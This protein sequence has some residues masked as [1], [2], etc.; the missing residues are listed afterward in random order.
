[1]KNFT[2]SFLFLMAL[3]CLFQCRD[4]SVQAGTITTIVGVS[5][6][7]NIPLGDRGLATD[8]KL[9]QPTGIFVDDAGSIFIADSCH[10]RIRKVDTLTGIITTVVGGGDIPGDAFDDGIITGD[11]LGDGGLATDAVLS[12]PFGVFVDVAGDIFIAD[13]FNDRI[14]KVNSNE[15]PT[16]PDK[17]FTF[18]C[19]KELQSSF[20]GI[21]RLVLKFGEK[22]HCTLKLTNL[23]P[24]LPVEIS[25]QL[26]KGLRSSIKIEP[27]RS[28]VD[29]NGE[30]EITITAIRK[31]VDWAAWAVKNDKG[32]YE[33]S[34]KMYD[35]GTA[36]GMFVVVR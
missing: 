3:S 2:I 9:K 16:I 27:A 5:V 7:S 11:E 22:E 26:W 14:R 23:E 4:V 34:K 20:A 25:S 6:G 36:W 33:F 28:I 17:S 24:R 32:R 15:I 18:R 29:A 12:S 8:A 31:G 10:G 30:L 19:N 1:M 13:T 21:K 35:L